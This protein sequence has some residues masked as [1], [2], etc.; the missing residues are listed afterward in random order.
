MR[1]EKDLINVDA[2]IRA[3]NA[4]VRTKSNGDMQGNLH[5]I[6][7]P[8][9]SLYERLQER[10]PDS[11]VRALPSNWEHVTVNKAVE[12][13]TMPK[14]IAVGLLSAIVLFGYGAYTKSAEQRDALIRIEEKL[15]AIERNNVQQQEVNRDQ[16]AWREVMNGHVR[17]IKG[18][19]TQ[20]QINA[21]ER[22]NNGKMNPNVKN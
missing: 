20:Q 18:M 12:S 21:L 3:N 9:K 8:K 5:R 7:R 2:G 4:A 11:I 22:L 17:E 10:L 1:R 6:R 19:L 13:V 14:W 15:H 16:Q